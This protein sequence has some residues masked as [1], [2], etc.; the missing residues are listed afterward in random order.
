MGRI[1][2]YFNLV[3][4]NDLKEDCLQ[5]THLDIDEAY[6]HVLNARKLV[7]KQRLVFTKQ[8]MLNF[9]TPPKEVHPA[10]FFRLQ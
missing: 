5:V 7:Q 1:S 9:E 8:L 6:P 10:N 2:D 4:S 3:H